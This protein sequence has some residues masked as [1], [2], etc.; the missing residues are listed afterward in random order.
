MVG[1]AMCDVGCH[2]HGAVR[3]DGLHGGGQEVQRAISTTSPRGVSP[4]FVGRGVVRWF[5]RLCEF[6]C[7]V[8]SCHDGDI[9]NSLLS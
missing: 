4:G 7:S 5:S 8:L 3:A 1:E 2:W 6:S 9:S